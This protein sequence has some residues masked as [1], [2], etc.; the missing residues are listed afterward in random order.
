MAIR[1]TR[2]RRAITGLRDADR[3]LCRN[4]LK[5]LA[6]LEDVTFTKWETGFIE[7]V[8]KQPYSFT[9]RQVSVIHN[10]WDKYCKNR[11]TTNDPRT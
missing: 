10:I 1:M 4:E 5:D 8:I 6:A 7:S 3:E 2:P 11:V 9:D